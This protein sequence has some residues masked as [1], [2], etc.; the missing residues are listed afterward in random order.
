M[1]TVLPPP[2]KRQ[3]RE[4]AERA[5][6]PI[7]Q[8]TTPEGLQPIQFRDADTGAPQG[9]VVTVSLADLTSKNL[10][11]LL[12]G[13]L[14]KTD[15]ND[16]LPYQFYNPLGDGELNVWVELL[17]TIIVRIAVAYRLKVAITAVLAVRDCH[18]PRTKVVVGQE[19]CGAVPAPDAGGRYVDWSTIDREGTEPAQQGDE[20][21]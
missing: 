1:A 10:S 21:E 15:P 5:L 18:R 17:V 11:L 7:V 9:P 3:K 13:L 16:R 2:S 14:G 12:N 19:V 20:D 4:D 8:P 6:H